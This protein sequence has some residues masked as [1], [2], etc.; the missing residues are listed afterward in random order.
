M[1]IRQ[2]E[3]TVFLKREG[4]ALQQ[5]CRVTIENDGPGAAGAVAAEAE[6]TCIETALEHIAPGESVHDVFLPA[7]AA[8]CPASF[9]VIAAGEDAEASKTTVDWRPP[10]QWRVHVIQTSHHD[11]GYTDF[12]SRV[13]PQH[14]A[15]LEAAIDM[16]EQTNDFDEDARFRLL[17]ETTWSL[18]HFLRTAPPERAGL[19]LK[20]LREGRFE[21]AALFG[22]V[23]TELCGHEVLARI[24]YPAFRLKREH[25]VPV[26]SAE[27]NDIPGISWGL[28]R[29]LTEA[30]IRYFCPGLP[31]YY[32]WSGEDLPS[33][34][35]EDAILPHPGPGGF[36]WEAPTGKRLLFWHNRTGCGGDCRPALPRLP[37]RLQE[38]ADQ[39]YP[40]DVVRWP[41]IGAARDN[42]PYI[43]DY[44]HTVR[45]WNERWA[46]PRLVCSTSARFFDEIG[47]HLPEDLPVH[48][49]ELPGQDYPVGAMSTSFA[50]AVNRNNHARLPAAEAMAA[51]ASSMTDLRYPR[52]TIDQAYEDTLWHDEHTWGYHFPCCGPVATA[53]KLEKAVHA[54]R[55]AGLA[56]DV[57]SKALA[58]IADRVRL[59]TPGLHLVVFN[60]LA[61]ARSEVVSAPLREWDNCGGEVS[62]VMPEDDPEGGGHL[63]VVPL[64]DRWHV[65]P[66]PEIAAGGFDLI[67]V[68][69]GK[70]V[71]FQIDEVTS[72]D[73]TV[74]YAPELLGTSY[75]G[76]RYGFFELPLGLRRHLRFMAENVP[77]MGYKTYRLA[78]RETPPPNV[79]AA[80]AGETVLENDYYRIDTDPR[81]GRIL[82][83][84]D[85]EMDR[86]L[87]DADAPH[88]FGEIVVRDPNRDEEYV[89]T[90]FRANP[91]TSGP[92]SVSLGW[93]AVAHGHP[94]VRRTLTLYRGLKR[95]EFAV[96]VL[97]D[98]TPLLDV[99][100]A[101]PFVLEAPRFRYEGALSVMNPIDDY[102][103][104]AQSDR[105]TVQNWVKVRGKDRTVL[106]SSLD[107][108]VV[109][110]GKLW[111][112]YVS[113]AH[114]CVRG[115]DRRHF[116][117]KTEDLAKGWVY[118][119][120]FNN[121]FQTNFAI[122]QTGTVLFR[123]VM[124]S[125]A[126]DF[127][128]AEAAAFGWQ[129][130][131]PIETIFTEHERDRT[132]PV[133]GAFL[134]LEPPAVFLVACKRAEDGRGLILRL[135]NMAAESVAARVEL[136]HVALGRVARTSFAEEDS[137]EGLDHE[138]HA[139]TLE[140]A[141]Q[142]VATVR[143][144]A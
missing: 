91:S 36:W 69:T 30:G 100:L 80:E 21:A 19:M 66:P 27:H 103:P 24:L 33:F 133:S 97:K 81:I 104:G 99:H 76:K 125:R 137:N 42:S 50:T 25:G 1:K 87:I 127:A 113:P 45:E 144:E 29:V 102:L 79:F 111:P 20:L 23:I 49:G 38:L 12:A 93:D 14:A 75:G 58:R 11:V 26:V 17:I 63:R 48:R 83:I 117:L 41:V 78:P 120:L 109:S 132:L 60:P 32:Q 18:V 68:A 31:S 62:R 13:L 129:A 46:Y 124:T 2:V 131:T 34:W 135:W 126:A 37:G 116:P 101:F 139:F 5:R 107:A 56:H 141:A 94:R 140:M 35:D 9:R 96:R 67:D 73:D 110:L 86:D 71:P 61:M 123:Y 134:K 106:W 114:R 128:D 115:D 6:G 43:A 136:P 57:A 85:K 143:V 112:G 98:P 39:D 88:A 118:S 40:Y 92:L 16:A 121:N 90:N 130:T 84:R 74:P 142:E 4:D 95:I 47:P 51:V 70:T 77:A 54:H 15:M 55:A 72:P 122:S 3:P 138:G 28:C 65:N 105:I 52:A 44:A 64:T 10:R 22:N 53:A 7:V 89:L 8:P 82:Q 119:N 108:P 59:D